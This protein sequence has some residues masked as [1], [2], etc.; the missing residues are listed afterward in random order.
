MNPLRGV[1][2]A[3]S[4][5]AWLRR[6]ASRRS[7]VRRAVSRF[8]PGESLDDGLRVAEV[9]GRE[10]LALILT[11]L[12]ENV[13]G[14][15]EVGAVA[16]DYEGMIDRLAASGLDAEVSVKLTQ[17]GFDLSSDLAFRHADVLAGRVAS[18]PGRFWIYMEGS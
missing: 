16:T 14:A 4:Q 13:T 7:F 1:F 17:L 18:L 3:G 11:H 6:Q 2:L 9:L 10:K 5:S 12:G 15:S 8:M